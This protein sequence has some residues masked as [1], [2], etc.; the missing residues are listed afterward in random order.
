MKKK[1]FINKDTKEL[2]ILMIRSYIMI[3]IS[4]LI[5]DKNINKIFYR[6]KLKKG[7][8]DLDNPKTFS[9]KLLYLKMY[10][11]NPLLS[12]CVDKYYVN[13]YVEACGLSEIL[14]KNYAVY[15]NVKD[16]N[17]DELPDRCFIQMNHM[18]RFNYI[19]NKNDKKQ[20]RHVK[21]VFRV[22]MHYNHYWLLREKAYRNVTPR[23]ICCE[24][25]SEDNERGLTDYKF[26]CFDG[27]P[28]YFMISYGE[29]DHNSVNI[30]LD[31]DWHNIDNNFKKESEL[32]LNDIEKPY[33]FDRMVEIA[34]ILSKGFPHVRVDLYN[35]KGKIYFGEMT[36]F[37]SGGFV[38]VYS[39]K[40]NK[41]I[42]EWINIDKYKND[43]IT[44]GVNKC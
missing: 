3:I 11:D 24:Y 8:A 39:D 5:G 28:K 10:Y 4:A 14:K 19:L 44:G 16:I 35:I 42:G 27:E 6:I 26:Y 7:S 12:T 33:N 34:R 1:K 9:E 22:L 36:F 20:V 30:K 41:V 2:I 37:S 29:F 43:L 15:L 25:L 31:M 21:R 18:S 23:I 13:K 40:M 17:L 32:N 38:N